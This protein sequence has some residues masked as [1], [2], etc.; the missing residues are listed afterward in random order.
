MVVAWPVMFRPRSVVVPKPV[1]DTVN[2]A[3]DVVAVPVTVVVER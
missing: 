3:T 2:A 1:P